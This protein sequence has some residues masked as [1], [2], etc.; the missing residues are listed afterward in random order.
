MIATD[1]NDT[2]HETQWS[3]GGVTLG[4]NIDWAIACFAQRL[5]NVSAAHRSIFGASQIAGTD[6][7]IALVLFSSTHNWGIRSANT[8]GSGS[9]QVASG[10][11]LNNASPVSIIVMH[12][13]SDAA[14]LEFFEAGSSIGTGNLNQSGASTTQPVCFGQQNGET[15]LLNGAHVQGGQFMYWEPSN[16][17]T[18]DEAALFN[19]GVT[20]PDFAGLQWWSRGI[21][22]NTP[23]AVP[24]ALPA[25][26]SAN[27]TTV[28]NA[29]D[30]YFP[31]GGGVVIWQIAQY[32]IPLLLGS[33]LFGA[34]L[35]CQ[36]DEMLGKMWAA[37]Q[38]VQGCFISDLRK[39]ELRE[40]V[41]QLTLNNRSYAT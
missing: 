14:E 33:G 2:T 10:S 20:I 21:A 11:A 34:N 22:I 5:A 13:E 41:N 31:L 32:W 36:S 8:A 7:G 3:A 25:T 18:N 23:A 17:F 40:I 12:D 26:S 16:P 9:N 29:I 19:G 24:S 1:A 35:M 4:G 37:M 27:M 39:W 28:P 38:K 30:A 6:E 15:G